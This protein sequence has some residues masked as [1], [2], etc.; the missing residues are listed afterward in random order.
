MKSKQTKE[1]NEN[2]K[3]RQEMKWFLI[4]I[5]VETRIETRFRTRIRIR[6]RQ[7]TLFSGRR[8]TKS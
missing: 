7:T 1:R 6:I 8:R 3:Q 5:R 4:R 2:K